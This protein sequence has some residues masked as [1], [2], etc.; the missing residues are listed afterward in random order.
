[1]NPLYGK[2][3]DITGRK[4][5]LFFSIGMFLLGSVLCGAAQNFLWLAICAYFTPTSGG[6]VDTEFA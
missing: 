3:S 4:P 2:L 6:L 1:M 5:I